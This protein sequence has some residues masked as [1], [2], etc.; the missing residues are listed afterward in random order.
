MMAELAER[1]LEK[2]AAELRK[3]LMMAGMELESD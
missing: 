2:Q 3:L 1:E